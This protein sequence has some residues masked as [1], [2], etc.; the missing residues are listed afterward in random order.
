MLATRIL[1]LAAL[2]C[3][4]IA[5]GQDASTYAIERQQALD[6]YNANKTDQALPLLDKL[7]AE[8]PADIAVQEAFGIA[9][10]ERN[11]TDPD[12][13]KRKQWCLKARAALLKA[14]DLGD[15]SNLL[16]NVLPSIPENCEAA[17]FSDKKNVDDIMRDAEGAFSRGDYDAALKGYGQAILL[18]PK[19]YTAAL[20]SGD[21]Y[22]KKGDQ[23][24]A[25]QW[26]ARAIQI[27]S[28]TETAYR[29]WGDALTVQGKSAEAREKYIDAIVAQP[30]MRRSWTGIMQ[31][32][33]RE[34]VQLKQIQI[35]PASSFNFDAKGQNTITL[36]STK[37][38]DTNGGAAW[39]G[40][41]MRRALYRTEE[42]PKLHPGEKYRRTLAEE[43]DAL[44]SVA[45]IA[46][47]LQKSG[48]SKD[49]DPQLA[50]L[51]KLKNQGLIE[52]YVL[53]SAPDQD[54]AQDYEAYRD[55]NRDKL[56]QYLSTYI[57]PAA[58]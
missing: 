54:I 35:Q 17:N 7:A 57:V 24:K 32:A 12:P 8:N 53:L 40:Y 26:Y 4:S 10:W 56:H 14:K 25:G 45:T 52:A 41:G 31:W 22:F 48:K 49:L 5:F 15:E 18:D 46:E 42:F 51:L 19:L 13:Q 2:M 20:F 21:V 6:L 47:Q 16:Q 38:G 23:D 27:D 11:S 44:T 9:A 29:Y 36:D 30:Y 28:N 1:V 43:T 34:K 39:V 33:Q 37:M 55:K 3:S 58:R 50:M